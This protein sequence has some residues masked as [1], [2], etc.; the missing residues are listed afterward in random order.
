[1]KYAPGFIEARGSRDGRVV[2]TEKRETSGAPAA[3]RLRPDR[4]EIST[5]GEDVS[6]VVVE[7]VDAKG[8]IVPVASNEVNF[9]VT[10]PGRIIGVGN[11]DPSCHES[12]KGDKRSAFNG[13]CIVLVQSLKDPG[14]IRVE[15]SAD[16]LTPAST[17]IKAELGT[18]RPAA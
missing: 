2:L 8:R 10:G 9:K 6:V 1:V 3:M 14:V 7:V 15:A 13:L 5:D 17:L 12:D 4:A 16:G 18:P 11:G